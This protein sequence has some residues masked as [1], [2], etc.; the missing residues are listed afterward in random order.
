MAKTEAETE[1]EKMKILEERI[2]APS[3]WC[4]LPCGIRFEDLQDIR[5]DDAAQLLDDH[6]LNQEVTYRSVNIKN[7]K[8][9]TEEFLNNARIWMKDKMSIA[10]VNEENEELIGVIIM[11]IQEKCAFSR[12]FS[13]VKLTYNLIYASIM[14]FYNE[15]EKSVNLYDK[16]EVRKYLKVYALALEEC[17]RH[18]GLGK[19][20]IKSA[21]SLATSAHV[22]AI[23][24]IF[25]S[26]RSQ[27]LAAE[28]GFVKFNEIYYNK[29][30]TNDQVLF[31]DTDEDSSAALMAYRIPDVEEVAD[32]EI[33][34]LARFNIET[35]DGEHN[36]KN[37]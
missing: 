2:K 31:T 17:Y 35:A 25:T 13:R 33:Q 3:I 18:K 4:R 30:F 26:Q 8:E 7:D 24:G 28:L 9:A 37:S 19:E 27:N 14:L 22:P 15:I 34:Q 11:R 1:I 16:L 29:Y 20:L 6:Y 10:A 12:T 21:I 36:S 5:Y 23:S 32:L